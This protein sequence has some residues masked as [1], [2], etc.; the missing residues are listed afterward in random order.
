MRLLQPQNKNR[1]QLRRNSQKIIRNPYKIK[2]I[3][4]VSDNLYKDWKF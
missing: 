2:I 4:K 3:S 1:V